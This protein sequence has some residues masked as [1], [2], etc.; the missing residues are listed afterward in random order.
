MKLVRSIAGFWARFILA[1]VLVYVN[2]ELLTARWPAEFP[3]YA[4]FVEQYWRTFWGT[5][6]AL[7]PDSTV[8]FF[9]EPLAG[10]A[11]WADWGLAIFKYLFAKIR[12]GIH[13]DFLIGVGATIVMFT[14][15]WV[16][17]WLIMWPFRHRKSR[18]A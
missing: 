7:L 17:G 10:W 15:L 1:S 13:G 16:V 8:G 5:A 3:E 6:T 11:Y 18:A 4:E 2:V 12:L 9:P 14:A